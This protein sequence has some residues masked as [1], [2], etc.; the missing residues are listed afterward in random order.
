ME[1]KAI[2]KTIHMITRDKGFWSNPRNI[3]EM[4]M[5]IVTEIS[6][7]YEGIRKNGLRVDTGKG[8][9]LNPN[10]GEELADATIRIFDLADALGVDL[11]NEIHKKIDTNRGR[12]PMHGKPHE[13]IMIESRI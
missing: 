8:T 4:C 10:V 9:I 6:E 11:E 13:G 12:L 7:L 3:G 2:T 5:L 1:I